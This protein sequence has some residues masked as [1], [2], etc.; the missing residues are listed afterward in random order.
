MAD[1]LVKFPCAEY[2]PLA[3]S[4]APNKQP[5]ALGRLGNFSFRDLLAIV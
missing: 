2:I 1:Q 3:A 5:E 4:F